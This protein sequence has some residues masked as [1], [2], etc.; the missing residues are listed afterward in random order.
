LK[1]FHR[2]HPVRGYFGDPRTVIYASRLGLFSFHNGIDISA[3][4][5]NAVY[6]VSSGVVVRVEPDE[7]VVRSSHRRRF[8]YMHVRPRVRV[9]AIVIESRTVLGNVPRRWEHVHLTE[10]RGTCVVNPLAPGHLSPYRDQT[11]PTVDGVTFSTPSGGHL[12]GSHLYGL[13]QAVARAGD[14]PAI[15]DSGVWRRMPVAPALVRWMITTLRGRR[16]AG[17]TTV[18]FRTTEPPPQDFCRV[19]APGTIQNFAAESGRY[20]WGRPGRYLFRLTPAP[21]D[22]RGLH[23][24]RY[25]LTVTAADTAGNSGNRTV[26]ITIDNRG[27]ARAGPTVSTDWRC[28]SRA[29]TVDRVRAFRRV[30]TD[31]RHR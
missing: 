2:Q 1:P 19:Y 3:W 9:G 18:D 7:V 13:V 20:Y 29:L 15:P 17:A 5:G 6:P 24:G 25:R 11:A 12:N 22:T 21:F 27:V 26:L 31:D 4:T 16:V 28:Q 10:I 14:T 30:R 8:Q 23:N